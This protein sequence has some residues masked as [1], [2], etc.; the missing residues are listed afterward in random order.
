VL[1]T[2]PLGLVLVCRQG[3]AGWMH[4]WNQGVC[5]EPALLTPLPALLPATAPLWQQPLTSLLAHQ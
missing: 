3:V 5:A 1:A 4:G 2:A